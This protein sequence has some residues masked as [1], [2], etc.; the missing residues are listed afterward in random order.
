LSLFLPVERESGGALWQ[1]HLLSAGESI[2]PA[3]AQILAGAGL[4]TLSHL[5]RPRLDRSIA[6]LLLLSFATFAILTDAHAKG[7]LLILFPRPFAAKGLLFAVTI[8]LAAAAVAWRASLL[9]RPRLPS[10]ILALLSLATSLP[11]IGTSLISLLPPAA[12]LY[13]IHAARRSSGQEPAAI[14]WIIA[15][16]AAVILTVGFKG[17][18]AYGNGALLLL[19]LRGAA[20]FVAFALIAGFSIVAVLA[21][22]L[23]PLG[24]EATRPTFLLRDELLHRLLTRSGRLHRYRPIVRSLVRRRFEALAADTRSEWAPPLTHAELRER[25]R[26]HLIDDRDPHAPKPPRVAGWIHLLA[27]GRNLELALLASCLSLLL[28]TSIVHLLLLPRGEEWPI[29][30]EQPW[31]VELYQR[32]LPNIGIA[33]G[34]SDYAGRDRRLRRTIEQAA[35]LASPQPELA[36]AIRALS[37]LVLDLMD[38]QR[39]V[40]RAVDRINEAA[41]ENG[42]PFYVD[43]DLVPVR[44]GGAYLHYLH[45]KTYRIERVRHAK[46]GLGTYTALWLSRSDRTNVLDA[47]LGWTRQNEHHGMIVLD[48]VREYWLTDVAPALAGLEDTRVQEIYGRHAERLTEEIARAGAELLELD[49]AAWRSVVEARLDCFLEDAPNCAELAEVVD[50]AALEVLARKVETHELQHVID[51]K[52]LVHPGPLRTV[53]TSYSEDAITFAAAELSAYLAEVARSGQPRIALVHFLALAEVQP[54]S[55]EGFAGR[56]ALEH[57]VRDGETSLELLDL[58][59]AELAAR[60]KHA[61]E[62]LFGKSLETLTRRDV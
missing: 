10:L 39:S 6:A 5:K 8:S 24:T 36:G 40:L 2:A 31:M 46:E 12:S 53:M 15:L 44:R 14:G 58:P 4:L 9:D 61:H 59:E 50:E 51:G 48:V 49:P 38:N 45:V 56:V 47:R 18:L 30:P 55:P 33:C 28:L 25:I 35:E 13:A 60:A 22:L 43:V 37:P 26:G 57:L 54:Y 62:Q 34:G 41:R 29:G 19:G 21:Q 7:D 27:R 23:D 3:L 1:W 11:L 32:R 42:V 20:L 17:A 52:D 16:P